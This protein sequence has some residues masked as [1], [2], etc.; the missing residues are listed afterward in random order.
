MPLPDATTAYVVTATFPSLELRDEYTAWLRSGHIADVVT[1][2][3]LTGEIV[4]VSDPPTP[5]RVQARYTFANP[6]ALETYVKDHAPRLRAEG[7]A[8]FPASRGV[9]F[10]R[11]VGRVVFRLD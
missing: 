8:R 1:A 4:E 6:Q 11:L 9:T 3:A 10:E 5:P 7:M 2:G